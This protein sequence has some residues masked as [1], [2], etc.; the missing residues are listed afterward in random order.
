MKILN[1]VFL[2]LF[3]VGICIGCG[4]VSDAPTTIEVTG[5]VTLDGDPV[6]EASV[7]FEDTEGK[8]KSYFAKTDN[9]GTFSTS[10]T[11]GKK[12]VRITA[13]REVPGKTVPDGA[14]TGTVPATEQFIPKK[15]NTATTLEEEVKAEGPNKLT[16]ELKSE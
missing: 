9:N 4:G 16:F 14:G 6:K 12:K 8:E 11:A 1:T 7:I 5:T 15:Y 13:I 3:C 2:F 10:M